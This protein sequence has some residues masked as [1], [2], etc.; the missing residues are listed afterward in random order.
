MKSV[1]SEVKL[2]FPNLRGNILL[3]KKAQSVIAL[4]NVLFWKTFQENGC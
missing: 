3:P 1:V 2:T 4:N